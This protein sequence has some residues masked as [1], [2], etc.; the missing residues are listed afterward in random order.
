MLEG[1]VLQRV[2]DYDANV[3]RTV[4]LLE[5]AVPRGENS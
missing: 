1:L 4:A 2:A 5:G 3:T